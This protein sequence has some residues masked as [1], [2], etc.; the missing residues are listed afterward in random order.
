[1][2]G[3]DGTVESKREERVMGGVLELLAEEIDRCRRMTMATKKTKKTTG[4]GKM[5]VT[6]ETLGPDR[7]ESFAD[8]EPKQVQTD[9]DGS[10]RRAKA[11]KLKWRKATGSDDALNGWVSTGDTGY[12]IETKKAGALEWLE[13]SSAGYEWVSGPLKPVNGE[14]PVSLLKRAKAI[15][16]DHADAAGKLPTKPSKELGDWSI[17]VKLTETELA[18]KGRELGD[19]YVQL[20]KETT[21]IARAKER[22]KSTIKEAE[23]AIEALEK[24]AVPLAEQLDTGL[25][26]RMVK[27]HKRGISVSRDAPVGEFIYTEPG[28]GKVLH[29]HMLSKGEQ[30]GLWGGDPPDKPAKAD[31]PTLRWKE[32]AKGHPDQLISG[33]YQVQKQAVKPT[34][35]V[36]VDHVW[37]ALHEQTR[38]HDDN[39]LLEWDTVAEAQ[40]VCQRHADEGKGAEKAVAKR[41]AK[42]AGAAAKQPRAG[43]Q[44]LGGGA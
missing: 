3:G 27:C 30:Q 5:T 40:A 12:A 35:K 14:T 43:Q 28:S 18:K 20:G 16:Q 22:S 11:G 38:L 15:C 2:A 7:V 23:G 21:N 44:P 19:L 8:E 1:M 41:G 10:K 17:P 4:K 9:A 6:S 36:L 13:G 25:E 24:D 33:P 32:F 31:P 42:V 34:G 39:D 29:R 37:I 26:E